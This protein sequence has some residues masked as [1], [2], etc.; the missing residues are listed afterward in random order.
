M[1]LFICTI[2]G[3]PG[4]PGYCEKCEHIAEK[5]E[6]LE[7][8]VHS[9]EFQLSD[10]QD[11]VCGLI[12]KYA[13]QILNTD[14]PSVEMSAEDIGQMWQLVGVRWVGKTITEVK[15]FCKHHCLEAA[16]VA[17][18]FHLFSYAKYYDCKTFLDKLKK[19]HEHLVAYKDYMGW[20]GEM[21]FGP[22][23]AVKQ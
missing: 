14:K 21:D 17:D 12:G 6:A 23:T 15:E 4:R 10:L 13:E 9:L 8:R 22:E 16:I 5:W 19:L 7:S 2:C 20:H 1:G 18:S 3:A 11:N